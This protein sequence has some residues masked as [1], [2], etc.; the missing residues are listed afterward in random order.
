LIRVFPVRDDHSLRHMTRELLSLVLALGSANGQKLSI[1]GCQ[2]VV[3]RVSNVQAPRH[4]ACDN[5][6]L[7][8]QCIH[9]AC[10]AL[11][12]MQRSVLSF[13]QEAQQGTQT[14][15]RQVSTSRQRNTANMATLS[16]LWTRD[17]PGALRR[18][19]R[20]ISALSRHGS[21]RFPEQWSEPKPP[22]LGCVNKS[23]TLS[24]SILP[25]AMVSMLPVTSATYVFGM[26]FNACSRSLIPGSSSRPSP[27]LQA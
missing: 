11:D 12:N 20:I 13:E 2:H 17:V 5:S 6:T 18:A 1:L 4:F 14:A 8:A 19:I 27:A 24:A 15:R 22:N 23:A 21:A 7:L 25:H 16:D 3:R 26:R 9:Y 10:S